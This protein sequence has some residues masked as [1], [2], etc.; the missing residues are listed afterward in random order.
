MLPL[1]LIVSDAP[2]MPSTPGREHPALGRDLEAFGFRPYRVRDMASALDVALQWRFDAV[3]VDATG[4]AA[5]WMPALPALRE[6]ARAPIVLLSPDD[7]EQWQIE[8]L[9]GGATEVIVM[10][11]SPRLVAAKLHRL[12]DVARSGL[13]AANDDARG[14]VLLGPLRLDPRRATASVGREPLALT[15]GEFGLLLLLASRPG[16]FVHRDA[17][18]QSLGVA[19]GARRSADMH[20]CRIRKKLR[21]ADVDG[22]L[23][24]DTVWG[25]GYCLRV[26]EPEQGQGSGTRRAGFA[27]EQPRLAR[28]PGAAGRIPPLA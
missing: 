23:S 3:L 22:V 20:V 14:L 21:E 26:A 4:R 6:R 24:I 27:L 9:R 5:A 8:A 17:I 18:A 12:L 7:D 10:P 16:E 25:R 1:C 13:E 11:A 15:A 2:A 19:A 28:S